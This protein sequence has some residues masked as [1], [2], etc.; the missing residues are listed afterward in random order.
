MYVVDN[1]Q[2]DLVSFLWCGLDSFYQ[3]AAHSSGKEVGVRA[4][5]ALLYLLL[6]TA[7]DVS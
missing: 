1:W 7:V 6:S 4:L 3:D 2:I 5:K